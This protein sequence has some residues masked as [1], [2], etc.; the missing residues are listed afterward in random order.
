MQRDGSEKQTPAT[1]GPD[2]FQRAFLADPGMASF[3]S[4]FCSKVGSLSIQT[5]EHSF[6]MEVGIS[7]ML[8]WTAQFKTLG[9]SYLNL[10]VDMLSKFFST[11]GPHDYSESWNSLSGPERQCQ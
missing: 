3:W 7:S 6:S 5:V 10:L 9:I 2:I 4:T 11:S 8:F 1:P